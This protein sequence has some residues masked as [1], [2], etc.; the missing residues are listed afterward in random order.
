MHTFSILTYNI[1]FENA[2]GL[3][4]KQRVSRIVAEIKTIMPDIIG[5]Q[6]V[7]YPLWTADLIRTLGYKIIISPSSRPYQELLAINPNV[8]TVDKINIIKFPGSV[9]GRELLIAG[10]HFKG[11]EIH[12]GVSHLESLFQYEHERMKQLHTVFKELGKMKNAFFLADTNL[13]CDKALKIADG[14]TDTFLDFDSPHEHKYTYSSKTNPNIKIKNKNVSKRYDR[15]YKHGHQYSVTDFKLIGTIKPQSDHYG[16]LV[17]L[18]L[19]PNPN[20][21]KE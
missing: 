13:H 12:V 2:V 7:I 6:E 18:T 15:I 20:G 1:W 3:D 16:V 14:W 4:Y 11:E 10:M 8:F 19:T 9:M 17:H 21:L 5:L